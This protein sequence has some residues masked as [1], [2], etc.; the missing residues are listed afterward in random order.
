MTTASLAST[1][2]D[3]F[4][5]Q[6]EARRA[7]HFLRDPR[8]RHFHVGAFDVD[9]VAGDVEIGLV[10][11]EKMARDLEH[12]LAHLDGGDMRGR[13]GH[14]GLAAV[15][16]AEAQRDLRR[17]AGRNDDPFHRAAELLG[18]DLRQHGLD[19]LPHGGRRRSRHGSGP[20]ARRAH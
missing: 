15:E 5:R 13:S 18:N 2:G 20:T 6:Q 12:L 10:G 7:D 3:M 4:A 19:A 16:A 17:I 14:H 1:P 11:F 8:H 9:M